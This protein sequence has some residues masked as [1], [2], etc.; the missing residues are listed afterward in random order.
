MPAD[1]IRALAAGTP[2]PANRMPAWS[3]RTISLS[4]AM[5][6]LQKGIPFL[7]NAMPMRA[8]RMPFSHININMC[9]VVT[10]I[11]PAP[12]QR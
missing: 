3:D 1:R 11:A 2:L 10:M 4:K 7:G 12:F 6:F 5:H 9:N 8:S